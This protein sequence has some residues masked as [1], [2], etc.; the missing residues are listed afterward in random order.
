MHFS[1]PRTLLLL[2]SSVLLTTHSA[3]MYAPSHTGLLPNPQLTPPSP[4]AAAPAPNPV[5]ASPLPSPACPDKPDI[6]GQ[7]VWGVQNGVSACEAAGGSDRTSGLC[8][9]E[10]FCVST[11]SLGGFGLTADVLGIGFAEYWKSMWVNFGSDGRG[12]WIMRSMGCRVAVGNLS[13]R[14]M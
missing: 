14:R 1:L 3:N 4:R 9:A 2:L 8:E 7:C 11:W 5:A 10:C 12:G 6:C 13:W